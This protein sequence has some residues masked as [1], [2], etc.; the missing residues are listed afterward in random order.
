MFRVQLSTEPFTMKSTLAISLLF[1]TQVNYKFY[2]MLKS[3]IT[4]TII[5][6]SLIGAFDMIAQRVIQMPPARMSHAPDIVCKSNSKKVIKLGKN[7]T[8]VGPMN[9]LILATPGPWGTPY[10]AGSRFA[11]I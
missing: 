11:N 10:E 8:S 1:A 3:W 6:V 4:F 9:P 5:Q 7:F 2:K